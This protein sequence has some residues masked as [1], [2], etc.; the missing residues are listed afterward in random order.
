M[1][2]PRPLLRARRAHGSAAAFTGYKNIASSIARS[3]PFFFLFQ[4]PSTIRDRHAHLALLPR[5]LLLRPPTRLPWSATLQL[6][7]GRPRP[8]GEGQLS[9]RIRDCPLYLWCCQVAVISIPSTGAPRIGR[10]KSSAA[11][12][13]LT[14]CPAIAPSPPLYSVLRMMRGRG[15]RLPSLQH[16]SPSQKCLTMTWPGFCLAVT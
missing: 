12:R 10:V 4:P 16:D 14:I 9:T 11:S 6:R 15:Q 2:K 5:I 7:K 1:R 3:L 8:R 13:P